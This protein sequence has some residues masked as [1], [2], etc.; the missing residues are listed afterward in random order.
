MRRGLLGALAVSVAASVTL[1]GCVGGSAGGTEH[2]GAASNHVTIYTGFTGEQAKDF[3]AMLAP[4]EKQTGIKVTHVGIANVQSVLTTRIQAGDPPDIALFPQ[5]GLIDDLVSRG[6]IKS[7][8]S[9]VNVSK[10][11][12]GIVSGV[13]GTT[14]VNGH[15]YAVPVDISVKSLVWYPPKAFQQAGYQVPT[16]W[17]QFTNLVDKM[18]QAGRTPLCLGIESGTGTGWPATDWLEDLLLRTS[19]PQAYD[20]WISH[21]LKF[22]SPQVRAA[23]QIFGKLALTPGNVKGGAKAIVT[24]KWDS[25]I[26]PMFNK[27]GP[28]CWMEKQ[29][30]FLAT[31]LP[32]GVKTG[33]DVGV[34]YFPGQIP[35]GYQGKPVEGA[36]D[37]AG[38]L[39]NNPAAKKLMQYLATPTAGT[40]WAKLGGFLS[41]W[42]NFNTALYPDAL[43]RQEAQIAEQ[44]TTFRF[45][46]SDAM[47]AAV[48]T[49][50]EYSELTAWLNG[51]ESLDTALKKIDQSWPTS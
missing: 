21:K 38:L 36:G 18:R 28:G 50:T 9:V 35:G 20:N 49:G 33:T 1:T 42:K 26:D 48:G 25:A 6:Q 19:G 34:F 13:L 7:L 8:D 5:P 44:A 14:T 15:L 46:A 22:D 47:P 45:D 23:A 51:D 3:D 32:S 30:S 29:G 2:A 43:T 40:P 16:T 10:L 31:S 37:L 41:P 27:G 11:K 39:T 17:A 12:S 24:T 4:F